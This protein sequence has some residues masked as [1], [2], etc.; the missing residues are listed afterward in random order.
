MARGP[1]CSS[2]ANARALVADCAARHRLPCPVLCDP[3]RSVCE[4]PDL[5]GC[6]PSQIVF[7]APDESLR[8]DAEAGARLQQPRHGTS[9]AAVNSPWQ[10]PGELLIDTAGKVRLAHRW[11]HCE[12]WPDPRLTIA[13]LRESICAA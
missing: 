7:D 3:T 8:V 13:A 6:K 2:S 9:R 1:R 5:L 11:Q 12:D 10:L 4:T